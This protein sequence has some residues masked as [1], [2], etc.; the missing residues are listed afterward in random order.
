MPLQ[1]EGIVLNNR[2][3]GS[4]YFLLDIDCQPIASLATPGQFVMLTVPN[5]DRPL[6]RRPFSIYRCTPAHPSK[7]EKRGQISI[8]YKQVG[9]GTLKM[10]EL[11][12]NQTVGLIG[13]LGQ[14]YLPPPLPSSDSLILIG[15]GMG[16]VSLVFLAERLN[17]Q[18]LF[19][20][21]GGKT[22]HDILCA[23]DFNRLRAHLLV[24][25]EDGSSGFKGTVI[26]LFFSQLER[27]ENDRSYYV[28]SCGPMEML[29]RLAG[30]IKPNRFVCQ[31]SLEARMACG[32]GACWGCVVKTMDPVTPYQRVCKEGP[33]F[34]LESIAWDAE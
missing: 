26:D 30:R 10:T 11:R 3:I 6:L 13:P 21:I 12:K 25:T 28:Y 32:F 5:G 1:T 34:P 18:D 14:G 2:K 33:V 29:K 9:T 22:E 17:P 27:F 15:G 19:V 7:I 31:V 24:A 16:I 8:L 20:F 23:R 4:T